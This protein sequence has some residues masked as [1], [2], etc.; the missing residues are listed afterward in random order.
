TKHGNYSSRT[1]TTSIEGIAHENSR[2]IL[3]SLFHCAGCRVVRANRRR[4]T[5]RYGDGRNRCGDTR[6]ACCHR[7]RTDR[8]QF[9]EHIERNWILSI[10]ITP[11]WRISPDRELCQL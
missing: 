4:S 9:S 1:A 7:K 8:Q 3:C 5:S 6:R 10:S 2:S 11:A